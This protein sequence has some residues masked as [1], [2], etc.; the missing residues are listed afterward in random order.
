MWKG[1]L[2]VGDFGL[3]SAVGLLILILPAGFLLCVRFDA[4]LQMFSAV[5]SLD[6]LHHALMIF[7]GVFHAIY[8]IISMTIILTMFSPIQHALLNVAKRVTVV[9]GF[10]IV[11][12]S[13]ASSVSPLNVFSAVSC[14][15]IIVFGN[16]HIKV[17]FFSFRLEISQTD[18]YGFNKSFV[19]DTDHRRINIKVKGPN[20]SQRLVFL[21]AGSPFCSFSLSSSYQL[22]LLASQVW[23]LLL[24][25]AISRH[26]GHSSNLSHLQHCFAS[27]LFQPLVTSLFSSVP[28][29][30]ASTRPG[31]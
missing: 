16:R 23:Y 26:S 24:L 12:F 25:V 29:P 1:K 30:L 27:L 9:L 21:Q 13:T 11:T 2:N 17:S 7:S 20:Q 8:N 15:T 4:V 14:I 3:L 5:L 6:D 22:H 28:L 18:K 10:F 19:S 31:R